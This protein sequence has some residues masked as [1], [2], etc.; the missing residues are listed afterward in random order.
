M[1]YIHILFTRDS[2]YYRLILLAPLSTCWWWKLI[3]C[4]IICCINFNLICS[5]IH[6]KSKCLTRFRATLRCILCL[7]WCLAYDRIY[8]FL[9]RISALR[10]CRC[11]LDICIISWISICCIWIWKC[12][13]KSC[14]KWISILYIC[15]SSWLVDV[16]DKCWSCLLYTSP[17]PRDA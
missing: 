14:S 1:W 3:C 8:L 2:A 11:R 17:S 9:E 7:K 13:L 15:W 16:L 4:S 5:L 12:C 10:N 6:Y